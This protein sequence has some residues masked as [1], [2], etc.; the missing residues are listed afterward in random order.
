M[1][2][3]VWFI[4]QCYYYY[5]I[6][7]FHILGAVA[8]GPAE[9]QKAMKYCKFASSALQ[10]EDSNTAIDNLSKALKLLTTGHD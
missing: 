6:N 4:T 2:L 10:Y 7:V 1:E 9:Y 3:L 5:L 8:L